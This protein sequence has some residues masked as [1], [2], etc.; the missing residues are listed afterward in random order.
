MMMAIVDTGIQQLVLYNFE[1][2]G[3]VS[4]YQR[5]KE[6][7]LIKDNLKDNEFKIKITEDS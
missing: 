7:L 3:E 5:I 2:V 6:I 1:R 4:V